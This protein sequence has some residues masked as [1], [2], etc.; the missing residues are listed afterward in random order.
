ML[1]TVEGEMTRE[2]WSLRGEGEHIWFVNALVT[3][4]VPGE[5]VDGRMTMIEFLMP[6]GTSPPRHFHPQDE[7]FTMIEGTL[8]FVAGDQRFVCEVGANWLVPGGVE[9]TFR[10]ESET[11]KL[12]AVYAPAG[13]DHCFRH[14]GMP[15]V[16]PT[17]P[18]PDAPTRPFEEIEAILAA[19]S[20]HNVGPPMGPD[21]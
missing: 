5:A 1:P 10:V 13:M 20:H 18:P 2:L 21:D 4:K 17:L 6:R 11:A 16:S 12:V 9:H 7:T 19:N 8:T 3:I 15:A 14:A